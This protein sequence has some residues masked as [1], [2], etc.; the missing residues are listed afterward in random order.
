MSDTSLQ[1]GQLSR[2]HLA[3]LFR[4]REIHPVTS[5]LLDME[6]GQSSFG[7]PMP[8]THN[9]HHDLGISLQRLWDDLNN[10]PAA[11]VHSLIV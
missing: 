10:S 9:P 6:R 3:H 5:D 11:A 4:Q 8:K 2:L 1:A 7:D